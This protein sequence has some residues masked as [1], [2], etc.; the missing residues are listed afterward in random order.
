[1]RPFAFLILCVFVLS[2]ACFPLSASAGHCGSGGCS[3]RASR[4]GAPV[5][6]RVVGAPVRLLG[7]LLP[8]NR[9]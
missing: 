4:A 2:V 8:R 6:R 3:A 9:R 7:R 1:M 5:V